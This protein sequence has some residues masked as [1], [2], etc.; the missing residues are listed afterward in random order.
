MRAV[1]LE[2]FDGGAG[3]RELPRPSVGAG[4]LLV[5]VHAASLNSLDRAVVAGDVRGRMEYRFPVTLG[6]DLAGVVEEVGSEVTRF[7]VGDEVFGFIGSLILHEGTFADYAL[8]RAEACLAHKPPGLELDEAA[9]VPLAG[10]TALAAVEAARVAA[11]D[12]VLVVGAT[13]GVGSFV[14]QLAARRDAAVIATGRD[15]DREYLAGLGA[16]EVIER[17][18]DVVAAVRERHGDGIEVVVDL[19]HLRAHFGRATEVLAPGG[20]A[21]STRHA[22][23]PGGPPGRRVT[24]E[25]V[26]AALE[27]S[28]LVEL[29]SLV[30]S[31]RLRVAREV[32]SLDDIVGELNGS[33]RRRIRGKLVA[34]VGS[35]R[36]R[37]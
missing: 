26:V 21:V 2:R 31:G 37:W 35:P 17:E 12:R 16:T 4:E 23:D 1:T 30:E 20:R 15:E 6:R 19:V 7:A 29:A 13:G 32:C 5:Q 28:R 36:A 14:V 34:V 11:G 33:A 22:A 10:V 8:C 25:N 18:R 3:L 24:A 27:P 9:A